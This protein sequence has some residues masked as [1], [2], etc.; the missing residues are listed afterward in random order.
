MS[1]I[2]SKCNVFKEIY[3]M[4]NDNAAT[5]VQQVQEMLDK[6]IDLFQ[7]LI[8]HAKEMTK[9][10]EANKTPENKALADM[11]LSNVYYGFKGLI[12]GILHWLVFQ[13]HNTTEDKQ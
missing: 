4:K 13:Q 1:A 7:P 2:N 5:N 8:E 3:D 11:A 9:Q 10:Y 6:G 12:E